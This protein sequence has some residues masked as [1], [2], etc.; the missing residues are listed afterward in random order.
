MGKET[1][2]S[3]NSKVSYNLIWNI[4]R[5]VTMALVGLL[6]VPYYI[7]EFGIAVYGI[8]PLA[9]SITS[10]VMVASD[11]LASSF[12]KYLII[13]IKS[14]DE[15][16]MNTTYSSSIIWMFKTVLKI[17]PIAILISIVSP[18]IFQ[19]GEAQA[20]DVQL[21]FVMI[22]ISALMISFITCLDSVYHAH[23]M[24]YRLYF[25]KTTYVILQV[26]L[27]VVFF[28]AFGS[29]LV[30]V[31]LSYVLSAGVYLIMMYIG[32]KRIAPMLRLSKADYDPVLLREMSAIG[33]W[34]VMT[35]IGAM[36]FIQASL[37]LVNL[38]LGPAYESEFAIVANIVS[39][40]NT[41]CLTFSQVSEP[42][43]YK[44]HADG[45]MDRLDTTLSIFTKF[46][47]LATVYP[48]VFIFTFISQLLVLWIGSEYTYIVDMTKIMLPANISVCVMSC[49]VF[50]PMIYNKIKEVAIVTCVLGAANI[51]LGCLFLWIM[52][53]PMGACIPWSITT[54]ALNGIFMPLFVAKIMSKNLLTFV[55]PIV[56]CYAMFAVLALGG[57][58]LGTV[59]TMP[60]S[61]LW[62]ILTAGVTY[63]IYIAVIYAFFLNRKEKDA[64][65]TYLPEK[66]QSILSRN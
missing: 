36:M 34:A 39:I 5:S 53:D 59:W 8:L 23:N 28:I 26:V 3:F 12:T 37:I 49:M 31:G 58:L 24:L 16:K 19:I 2:G 52:D 56:I 47:G 32:A 65:I 66:L 33:L 51:G 45:D 10:Y 20:I 50:I 30:L 40:T 6:M 13:A 21:M 54:F 43:I 27:I 35:K 15:R 7:D 63:L 48:I 1:D 22:F 41:A 38:F 44:T 61:W 62:F 60:T 29:S 57:Y 64:L 9:T 11:S 4:I 25:I 17:A 46:V 55:K 14:G 18:Y 42:L